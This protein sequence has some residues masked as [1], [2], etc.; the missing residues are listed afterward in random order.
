MSPTASTFSEPRIRGSVT[1]RRFYKGLGV[2]TGSESSTGMGM[3]NSG[4][5]APSRT[6]IGH[7]AELVVP[8]NP[9]DAMYQVHLEQ[10][11]YLAGLG[12]V[13]AGKDHKDFIWNEPLGTPA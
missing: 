7:S 10:L 9:D 1:R 3:F 12:I 11:S 2:L 4:G 13:A 6:P 5:N 8:V